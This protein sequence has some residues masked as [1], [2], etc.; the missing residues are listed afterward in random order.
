MPDAQQLLPPQLWACFPTVSRTRAPDGSRGFLR[1]D[2]TDTSL[3]EDGAALLTAAVDEV[4][5]NVQEAAVAHDVSFLDT[6]VDVNGGKIL[7][8]GG[9]PPQC[10]RRHRSVAAAVRETDRWAGRLPLQ[11]GISQG[12]VFTGDTG[13]PQSPDVFGEGRRRKSR[14]PAGRYAESGWIMA[15]DVLEHTRRSYAISDAPVASLKG[16]S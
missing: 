5:R 13:S 14:R 15:A 16:K 6:D 1:F 2:G 10:R 4:L 9:A 7:L 3:A 11:T 8:V 12:R